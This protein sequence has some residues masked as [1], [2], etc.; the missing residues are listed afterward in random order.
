MN[1]NAT[2]GFTFKIEKDIPWT[3]GY[4]NIETHKTSQRKAFPQTAI[5][6]A[7]LLAFQR[8]TA[9]KQI[10]NRNKIGMVHKSRKKCDA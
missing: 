9:T 7:N 6:V 8:G 1:T 10:N 5:T 4:T 3:S 2:P